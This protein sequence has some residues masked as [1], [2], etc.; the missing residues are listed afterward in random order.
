M[1]QLRYKY[2][3][4]KH[5]NHIIKTSGMAANEVLEGLQRRLQGTNVPPIVARH[6]V[7]AIFATLRNK[8]SNITG[9]A[10]HAALESCLSRGKKVKS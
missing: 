5:P 3:C 4:T 6:A 9:D 10:R 8:A 7:A 2:A 1:T